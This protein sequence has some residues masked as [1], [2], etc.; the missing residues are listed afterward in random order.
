MESGTAASRRFYRSREDRVAGGVAGGLAHAF[1]LDPT[2]VR[3]AFVVLAFAGFGVLAYLVLWIVVLERPEG[4]PE[5]AITATLT[6]G[7][8]RQLAGYGLLIL[9]ALLLA[10]DLGWLDA[11]GA[12]LVWPLLLVA[13]G[14]VLLITRGPG[15]GTGTDAR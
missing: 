3:L 15:A 14:V 2:L 4:E 5:P 7:R 12:R 9:G 11:Y 10:A 1:D 8:G 6:A 13:A